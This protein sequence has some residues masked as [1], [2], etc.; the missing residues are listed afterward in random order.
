ME[1]LVFDYNPFSFLRRST[2]NITIAKGSFRPFFSFHIKSP[3]LRKQT[4]SA[5]IVPFER[6]STKNKNNS[7]YQGLKANFEG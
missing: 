1:H 7:P 5:M 2:I 3:V 6:S 4:E